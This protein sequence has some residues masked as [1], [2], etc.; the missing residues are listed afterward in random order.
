MTLALL[1]SLLAAAA[2]VPAA[3]VSPPARAIDF[4]LAKLKRRSPPADVHSLFVCDD[5]SSTEIVVCAHRAGPAYPLEEMAR[6]FEPK[7]LKAETGLGNGV[8]GNVH[9]EDFVFPNGMHS[10]R[11]MVGIKLPF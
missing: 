5:L 7:P 10:K 2:P 4:D 6:I 11:V 9:V 1:L 3:P 8:T